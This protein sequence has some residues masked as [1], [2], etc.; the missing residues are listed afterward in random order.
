M[1][2]HYS[3]EDKVNL[4][5]DSLESS[6]QD[7]PEPYDDDYIEHVE[8][9]VESYMDRNARRHTAPLTSPQEVMNIIHKLNNKKAPGKDGVKNIA[10]KALPLNHR[11]RL[12]TSTQHQLLR[13]TNKIIHGFNMKS[14]TVGVFLDVKK[15]FDRMWHDGLIYKMIKLKFPTYLGKII[16]HYLDNRTFNVK[17]ISTS[18]SSSDRHI[19]SGTLQGLILSPAIYNI[20]TSDSSSNPSVSVCVF[21]DDDAI[22]CNSITAEQAVQTTQAYLS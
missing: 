13:V 9:K 14:Y 4:L 15:A 19:A 18:S 16:H 11:F 1:G 20:Y 2:L 22:L 3:T 17:I 7:N 10:L 5:A 21:V 12:E 8:G 6:F